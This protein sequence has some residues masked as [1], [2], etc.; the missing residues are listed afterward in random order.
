METDSNKLLIYIDSIIAL[1]KPI[2]EAGATCAVYF[3]LHDKFDIN[4]KEL[5]NL[6]NEFAR[7]D[8]G[9]AMVSIFQGKIHSITL[10]KPWDIIHD[11]CVQPTKIKE[12]LI[13]LIH[14]LTPKSN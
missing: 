5:E 13:C 10:T 11:T 12:D 6:E 7:R 1:A 4:S 8:H 3:I 2:F 14:D 9:Q